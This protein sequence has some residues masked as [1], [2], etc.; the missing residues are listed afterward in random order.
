MPNRL[1]CKEAQQ[2]A[3][4]CSHRC[5][6][7]ST[8]SLRVGALGGAPSWCFPT[9][10]SIARSRSSVQPAAICAPKFTPRPCLLVHRSCVEAVWRAVLYKMTRR[11][12]GRP[13]DSHRLYNNGLH[14]SIQSRASRLRNGDR[15]S[16]SMKL[17][18]KTQI[19]TFRANTTGNSDLVARLCTN[20]RGREPPSWRH[21][22]RGAAPPSGGGCRGRACAGGSW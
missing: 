12:R 8:R 11:G 14:R 16:I 15:C 10:I 2:C 20:V 19:N 18:W 17:D 9:P 3:V 22:R 13:S 4:V 5:A 6:D 7:Q 1:A 21:W